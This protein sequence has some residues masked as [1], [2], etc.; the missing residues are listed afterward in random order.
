MKSSRLNSG[1]SFGLALSALAIL[2]CLLPQSAS[3]QA[4]SG[5][6]LGVVKDSSGAVVP[7]ASITLVNTGTGLTRTI[8]SDTK[9]EYTAPLLPTGTYTVNAEMS[10]FKKV[11]RPTSTSASTPR[12]PTATWA[13]IP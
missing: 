8:V 13:A 5:T 11:S 2:C 12:A 4:V 3:A 9:G 10:G 1:W 6:I 7:G